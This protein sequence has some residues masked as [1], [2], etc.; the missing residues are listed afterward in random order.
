MATPATPAAPASE[1]NAFI[2]FVQVFFGE[3]DSR[4]VVLL[5]IVA[6]LAVGG[7]LWIAL[8]ENVQTTVKTEPAA[9]SSEQQA[10]TDAP[11]SGQQNAAPATAAAPA[12]TTE[13]NDSNPITVLAAIATAAVGGIAGALKGGSTTS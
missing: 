7:V 10:A 1:R 12:T 11:S 13:T 4:G 5:G 2:R 9:L 6:I 8:Q 3:G